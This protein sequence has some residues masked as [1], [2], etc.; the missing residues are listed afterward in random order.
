MK[1]RT[2]QSAQSGR[3]NK[4]KAAMSPGRIWIIGPCLLLEL[5]FYTLRCC[6][7][8]SLSWQQLLL[9]HLWLRRISSPM[10]SIGTLRDS[11]LMVRKLGPF[12]GPATAS[13]R[14]CRRL[15]TPFMLLMDKLHKVLDQDLYCNETFDRLERSIFSMIFYVVNRSVEHM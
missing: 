14:L 15:L 9:F 10:S 12:E 8:N 1:K 3:Y 7:S 4:K 5:R 2:A 6:L 13:L 11:R